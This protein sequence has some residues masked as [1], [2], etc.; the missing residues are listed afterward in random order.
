MA[1]MV[2]RAMMTGSTT[3]NGYNTHAAE[4]FEALDWPMPGK[5][6]VNDMVLLLR[7]MESRIR[8]FTSNM[9]PDSLWVAVSVRSQSTVIF[10]KVKDAYRNPRL[11]RSD[12]E[13]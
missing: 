8:Q 9:G 3:S 5:E 13:I 1:T 6:E 12:I 2:I 7:A 11:T 10:Y 4:V